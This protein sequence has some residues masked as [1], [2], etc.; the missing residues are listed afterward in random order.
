MA[1]FPHAPQTYLLRS[2]DETLSLRRAGSG[3]EEAHSPLHLVSH[4]SEPQA[5]TVKGSSS[6]LERKA[7]VHAH[8]RRGQRRPEVCPAKTAGP[9]RAETWPAD[10]SH[11][12][13][14]T[15]IPERTWVSGPSSAFSGWSSHCYCLYSTRKI[16]SASG[17]LLSF[18]LCGVSA[19]SIPR[20][21]SMLSSGRPSASI[22]KPLLFSGRALTLCVCTRALA[23]LHLEPTLA[24]NVEELPKIIQQFSWFTSPPTPHCVAN[25]KLKR[26]VG[27]ETGS[28]HPSRTRTGTERTYWK[29]RTASEGSFGSKTLCARMFETMMQAPQD[30]R[31]HVMTERLNAAKGNPNVSRL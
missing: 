5:G 9:A 12:A 26:G 1:V 22:S 16:S 7:D 4:H 31:I 21:E 2:Q 29:T 18:R 15:Y 19:L 13:S 27:V 8:R 28:E 25:V 6:E 17:G 11:M 10:W 3:L 20:T 30:W 24:Y 14:E 23:A